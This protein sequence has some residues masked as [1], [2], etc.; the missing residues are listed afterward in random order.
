M[1]VVCC[2]CYGLL[3][4]PEES[5]RAW[6]DRVWSWR[7]DNEKPWPTV[8]LLRHG[9][10]V[11]TTMK[12]LSFIWRNVSCCWRLKW[13]FW[14]DVRLCRRVNGRRRFDVRHAGSYSPV[15][16]VRCHKRLWPSETSLWCCSKIFGHRLN[17]QTCSDSNKSAQVACWEHRN[18]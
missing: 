9:T 11:D 2:L 16:M 4:C 14:G 1:S 5:Y 12:M 10:K 3:A 6:C 13:F 7:L 15:D 17:S 8:G 18:V